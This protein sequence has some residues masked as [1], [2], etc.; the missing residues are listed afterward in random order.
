MKQ[1]FITADFEKTGDLERIEADLLESK[2]IVQLK[3]ELLT[4][5]KENSET[6]SQKLQ[7]LQ[8]STFDKPF[9]ALGF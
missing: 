5:E 4:K 1:E 8:K 3:E 2:R 6:V 9:F 7:E